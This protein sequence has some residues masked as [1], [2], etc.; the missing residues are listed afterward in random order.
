MP[1]VAYEVQGSHDTGPSPKFSFESL[2]A[3][4][5]TRVDSLTGQWKLEGPG[6]ANQYRTHRFAKRHFPSV[7]KEHGKTGDVYHMLNNKHP[8]VNVKWRIVDG[9]TTGEK[10]LDE[11]AQHYGYRYLLGGVP[12]NPL[13]VDCTGWIEY[14]VKKYAGVQLIH[15]SQAMF[16]QLGGICSPYPELHVGHSEI[17]A[18]FSSETE[19]KAG[20]IVFKA[21]PN[22]VKPGDCPDHA[23]LWV[24]PGVMRDTRSVDERLGNRA[25]Y[26]GVPGAQ[27]LFGRVF[28]V[29]GQLP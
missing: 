5:A 1:E 7:M 25:I 26:D 24:A 3:R 19:C 13:G 9:T 12:Y 22:F 10:M 15:Q 21:W 16:E 4:V 29:N 11:E 27:T 17:G 20:D 23:G 18:V 8:D 2:V 14:L 28:K 6:A